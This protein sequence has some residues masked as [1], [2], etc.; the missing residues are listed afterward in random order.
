MNIKHNPSAGFLDAEER[1]DYFV[2]AEMKK[3]WAVQIDLVLEIQRVCDKYG[4]KV[5]AEGGTLIGAVRHKGYIPWDD[6]V[7]LAMMRDDYDKLV[8]VAEEEFKQPYFFQTVY[9]DEHYMHRH[10]QL[11]NSSTAAWNR[12]GKPEKCNSGIFVDIFVLDRQPSDPRHIRKHERRVWKAKQRL[13]F[14]S[15]FINVL[16]VP[17]YRFLRNHVPCLSDKSLFARYEAVMRSVDERKSYYVSSMACRTSAELKYIGWYD[18]SFL[19]DFEYIKLRVMRDYDD[20]LRVQYGDWR[21]PVKSPTLHGAME[22]DTEHSYKELF[23]RH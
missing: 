2:T 4:L 13:K 12:G 10:A 21:T 17:V 19:M 16:P 5:Y 11:R 3:V 18:D 1:C 14:V 15:K 9:T 22:F 20:T 6:D 7:D 8:A 23:E